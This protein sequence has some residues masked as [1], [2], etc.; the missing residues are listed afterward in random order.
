VKVEVSCVFGL[1]VDEQPPA[2]DVLGELQ[3]AGEDVLEEAGSE[4]VALVA[5]VDAE[6]G[7]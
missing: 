6:P 5:Y 3:Q 2:T 7:K 4:P 1:G